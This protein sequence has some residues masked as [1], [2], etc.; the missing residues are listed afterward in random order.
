MSHRRS[1]KIPAD[2]VN[3]MK[4]LTTEQVLDAYEAGI[5]A[6]FEF[7][8]NKRRLTCPYAKGS[9][10]YSEWVLGKDDAA[11][12]PTKKNRR[13]RTLRLKLA[14]EKGDHTNSEWLSLC[15]E[16]DF[17]CVR[18]GQRSHNLE[19]DHITPVYQR[20]DNSVRNLQPLCKKCNTSKGP[21]NRNWVLYRRSSGFAKA[22]TPTTA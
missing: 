17:R 16:F 10:Q 13:L 22:S 3:Q 14:K 11:N 1:R 18:C 8:I 9:S 5:N 19:K 20:G 2:G 7:S 21:E 6:E 4:P 15:R 12:N